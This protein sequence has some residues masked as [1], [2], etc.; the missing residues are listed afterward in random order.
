[1]RRLRDSDRRRAEFGSQRTKLRV[2]SVLVEMAEYYGTAKPGAG[3]A[4]VI[5]VTQQELASASGTS[6]ESVVRSLRDLHN[7]GLV[8][9]GRGKVIVL[10]PASL[11]E[12]VRS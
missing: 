12:L 6:R 1:M 5:A 10:D 7:A 2:A 11:A 3:A 4:K 9:K 8:E